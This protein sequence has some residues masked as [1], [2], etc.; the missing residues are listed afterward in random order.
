M[1]KEKLP[2]VIAAFEKF[3]GAHLD[4]WS[5]V[6]DANSITKCQEYWSRH[7]NHFDVFRHKE[8]DWIIMVGHRLLAAGLQD[9]S[10]VKHDDSVSSVGLQMQSGTSKD[11]NFGSHACSCGSRTSSFKAPRMKEMA[12]LTQL[13]PEEVML[14]K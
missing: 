1:V 2:Y 6:K 7:V 12:R 4:Y 10:D 9:D 3:Q 8:N 5:E 11:S 14:Q 13:K